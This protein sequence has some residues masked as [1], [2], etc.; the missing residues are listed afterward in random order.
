MNCLKLFLIILSLIFPFNANSILHKNLSPSD[1]SCE[2]LGEHVEGMELQNLFGGT[3]EILKIKNTKEV[4]RTFEK[5]ICQGDA[6]LSNG[7]EGVYEIELYEEDGDI[8]YK[9]SPK[10]DF[11][12]EDETSLS[13]DE[14]IQLECGSYYFTSLIGNCEKG[15]GEIIFSDNAKYIGEILDGQGT[16]IGKYV[17]E[18]GSYYLGEFIDYNFNGQGTLI[19][20]DGTQFIGYFENGIYQFGSQIDIEGITISD[21]Y[22]DSIRCGTRYFKTGSRYIGCTKDGIWNDE[23]VEYHNKNTVYYGSVVN[24]QLTDKNATLKF[25]DSKIKEY[26]GE[27]VNYNK[28][29]KGIKYLHNGHYLTGVW[30]KNRLLDGEYNCGIN[31]IKK[32][33]GIWEIKDLSEDEKQHGVSF[34][35]LQSICEEKQ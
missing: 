8:W 18:D 27:I 6:K 28:E 10:L 21:S 1:T 32:I 16:G 25:F 12:F 17:F 29:G 5:L 13:S 30:R 14:G 19:Y 2:E 11:D 23:K 15:Y 3:F 4:S 26:I 9:V 34:E 22:I 33:N 31:N 24:G 35:K 20:S 7:T